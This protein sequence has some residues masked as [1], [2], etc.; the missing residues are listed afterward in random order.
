M[1]IIESEFRF[2][3]NAPYDPGLEVTEDQWLR[4]HRNENHFIDKKWLA[5]LAKNVVTSLSLTSYP[6]S[7][8]TRLRKKLGDLYGVDPDQIY[9]GNGSDEILADLFHY[10][11]PQFTEAVIQDLTYRVYPLLLQRYDYKQLPLKSASRDHFSIVDSPNSLT[12]QTLPV[13]D[14]PSAFLIWDNVYGEFANDQLI[15]KHINMSTIILRSFSK[16]YGL[17]NLRIGYGISDAKIIRELMERKDIYNVNGFAQEMALQVLEHKDYFDSLIPKISQARKSLENELKALGFLLS[18]S[19]ANF[20]WATHPSVP[21]EVIQKHL[22][23]AYIAVRRFP[24]S[25][26]NSYL[27]ITVPP[28][29]EIARIIEVIKRCV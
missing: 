3:M 9:I 2:S 28:L 5:K 1:Q 13:F 23:Q 22:E 16:F 21:S 15:P 27:R 6:D 20:V 18:N 10:L 4:L 11:R 19:Q 8:C 24:E 7:S 17:A 12:G 26:I 29:D 14:I 25:V